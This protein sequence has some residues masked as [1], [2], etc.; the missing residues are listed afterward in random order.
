[1]ED[2][3]GYNYVDRWH[4]RRELY[5][6]IDKLDHPDWKMIGTENV[7][8]GGVRGEYSLDS[9]ESGFRLPYTSTM[10][11]AEQLWKFTALHDY[12]CGDFM[13]TGIDYLGES[14]WPGRSSNSGVLDLAG[15]PKD[16]YYFYQSQ[17]TEK[18][19]I[20]LFPHWNREGKEG[21]VIPVLAYSNCDAV[22]LFLNGK[23]YGEKRLEL[24]RPGNSGSW[25]TYDKPPV[26]AAT[27]DLHLSWDVP[28]EPGTLKAVGK[29]NGEIVCTETVS[30]AGEPAALRITADKDALRANGRDVVHLTVEIVDSNGVVVPDANNEIHFTVNGEARLIGVENGNSLDHTPP[31]AT[32][33]KAF[34]GLILGIVQATQKSGKISVEVSSRGIEGAAVKMTAQSN[35]LVDNAE[36]QKAGTGY[37]FTEGPAVAPDGRVYFTDQ[38]ND[39]IYIWDENKGISLFTEQAGR[40][41]G[42]YF[43]K[44]GKLIACA[45]LQNQLVVFDENKGMTVMLEEFEGKHLNGP[46]DLWIAPDGGIYFSDPY[47]R[48]DYWEEGHGEVQDAR[49]V[50]YLSPEGNITRVINDF[51]QPNGLVGTPDGKTLYV[52]DINDKKIWKYDIQP[53]GSLTDKT[54]FAPNGS[55]GMTTDRKGNVYL[56]S[57]KVL[58]YSPQAELIAEIEVPEMPS[59]VCFGGKNRNILFITARTSVYT[60]K[61]KIKGV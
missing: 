38:P 59:N 20:H 4:E 52:S 24:P 25:M 1:M 48:R 22:E 58:V 9:D 21:Q 34:N 17:W 2:V 8:V 57:G 56:T 29:I 6:S 19:M 7:S 39:R 18:P 27:A 28:Y 3:V 42:M 31:K 41:N 51:K 5:Y 47:Y 45:D 49:G 50:Y 36:V 60:I 26:N 43:N 44:E 46:N 16:G 55:D 30:T 37:S 40:S 14:R 10:I 53:D 35:K 54:F 15:F 61:M 12:V 13:W 32:V 11:R 33:K 23:S